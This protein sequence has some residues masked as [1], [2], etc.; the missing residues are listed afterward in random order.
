MVR[1]GEDRERERK[2]EGRAEREGRRGKRK[3]GRKNTQEV[4]K[5]PATFEVKSYSLPSLLF[6]TKGDIAFCPFQLQGHL[7]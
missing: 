4:S 7:S 1:G 3:E 5:Y 6:L 2:E